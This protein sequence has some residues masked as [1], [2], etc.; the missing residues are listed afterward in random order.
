[1]IGGVPLAF[2]KAYEFQAD[3][4]DKDLIARYIF[5]MEITDKTSVGDTIMAQ[6]F[7][8]F[9]YPQK[10]EQGKTAIRD[11]FNQ[12]LDGDTNGFDKLGRHI[13]DKYNDEYVVKFHF[14][15]S[16]LFAIYMCYQL[17]LLCIDMALRTFK[18]IFLEVL[19]PLI[20]CAYI[21][22]ENDI[23][24]KWL[25]EVTSTFLIVF[26]KLIGLYF[27]A[28]GLSLLDKLIGLGKDVSEGFIENG[29]IHAFI[30]IGLL[31][32]VKQIP[33][34]FNK[35]FGIKI[36]DEGG[37]GGRLA[38]MAGVGDMAKKAWD[39]VKPAAAK[40]AGV[41]GLAA[42]GMLPAALGVGAAAGAGG[43]ALKRGWNK[44]FGTKGAWK[45][46]AG[47]HVLRRIGAGTK[48]TAAGLTAKG[49]II[50]GTKAA[51]ESYKKSDIYKF[52]EAT[53]GI[54]NRDKIYKNNKL[55]G[56]NGHVEYRDADGNIVNL[57]DLSD[58]KERYLHVDKAF[59]N[60]KSS[61]RKVLQANGLS[62]IST[63]YNARDNA[64]WD[65]TGFETLEK[66]YNGYISSIGDLRSNFR[67]GSAEHK[68]LSEIQQQAKDGNMNSNQVLASLQ[69]ALRNGM[70]SQTMYNSV[71]GA[72]LN[73][74][75]F[76]QEKSSNGRT[77][78]E[79]AGLAN[80]GFKASMISGAKASAE[81]AYATADARLNSEMTN[82]S[83]EQKSIVK[84]LSDANSCVYKDRAMVATKYY[85]DGFDSKVRDGVNTTYDQ[86][87]NTDLGQ[88]D[89]PEW[90]YKPH[91]SNSQQSQN[92]QSSNSNQQ[93]Q[94]NQG[95]NS[96]SNNGGNT[97]SSGNQS[98]N[99]A[100]ISGATINVQNL[101]ANNINAQN[102][103]GLSGNSVNSE[104]ITGGQKE[105]NI[106]DQ[107]YDAVK[108]GASEAD[109]QAT[110]HQASDNA[111]AD[112]NY[113]NQ[114]FDD[115]YLNGGFDTSSPNSKNNNS[116]DEEPDYFDSFNDD[117]DN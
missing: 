91:S 28:Y 97:S 100:T 58:N 13:N 5:G 86:L 81:S 77:F 102:V 20:I 24:K 114:K 8:A 42:S 63:T 33:D 27:M 67:A 40:V 16:P 44:G 61:N 99:G 94:N 90:V 113:N 88:R 29:L 37:I 53:K 101:N 7:T 70:I 72:A 43:L 19:T 30:M 116:Y 48:A 106:Y 98:I 36:E 71:E 64:D 34:I 22:S 103:T 107:I 38:G 65:K 2:D 76:A 18:L 85:D 62:A 54:K 51:A 109:I 6:S 112:V 115:T 32:L 80:G 14:L 69:T 17:I 1:M 117:D 66:N 12:I 46:R 105:Q 23:L 9:V 78:G 60:I 49:G 26:T 59:N 15:L 68:F 10:E 74:E 73:L 21:Y 47:G 4:L 25:K 79:I 56:D 3:V 92:N 108:N 93:N 96:Q 75:R 52:D 111:N 50:A 35:I 11:S 87:I 82:L 110:V 45:D 95:G 41:A 84:Y 31:Q 89:H 55:V 104:N 83:E 39:K 57:N